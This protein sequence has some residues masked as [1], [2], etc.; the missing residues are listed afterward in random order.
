MTLK[1]YTAVLSALLLILFPGTK[2]FAQTDTEIAATILHKDSLFWKSY[3]TCDTTANKT[4]FTDDVEFYHDKGGL[5]LSADSLVASMKNNLCGVKKYRLRREAI[6]G[7]VN[8]FPL[9][10]NGE[11]YGAIIS[12]AHVFYVTE[13]NKPEYLDGQAFFTHVWL[14]KNG[15]WKMARI[16]SYNH[17]PAEYKNNHAEIKLTD[18]ALVQFAGKYN[19][20][21]GEM[22]VQKEGNGLS[23]LLQNKTFLLYPETANRFFVRDRDLTFEFVKNNKHEVLKILVREGDKLVEEAAFI[24]KK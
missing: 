13:G 1:F 19:S 23:L 15:D 6:A 14:F 9:R 7:S 10:R 11:I 2:L 16:L 20:P 8:V 5:T 18:A 12:G 17:H 24:S 3:N 4:F 21:K 22:I